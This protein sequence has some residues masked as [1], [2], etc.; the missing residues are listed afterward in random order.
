MIVAV[1]LG[2]G[3]VISNAVKGAEIAVTVVPDM[4]TT[5]NEYVAEA[6]EVG[7]IV[8]VIGLP[9]PFPIISVTDG[10]F[11][12]VPSGADSTTA[13]VVPTA[14]P[15]VLN[16]TGINEPVQALESVETFVII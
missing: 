13:K 5:T 2:I 14:K 7:G 15:E 10:R 1:K 4:A 3:V 8:T 6:V 11:G 12:I 16:V 9:V